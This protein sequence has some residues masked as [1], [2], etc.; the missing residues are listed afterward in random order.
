LNSTPLFYQNA[1]VVFGIILLVFLSCLYLLFCERGVVHITIYYHS[2][3][4]S[5]CIFKLSCAWRRTTQPAIIFF[6]FSI[7]S[8]YN[9]IGQKITS[10]EGNEDYTG[11]STAISK[12]G[13]VIAVGSIYH[14]TSR[15]NDA[16]ISTPQGGLVRIYEW[17]DTSEEWDQMGQNI[18]GDLYTSNI[19][20]QLGR[21][22]CLS[23]DGKVVAIYAGKLAYAVV[24]EWKEDDAGVLNWIKRATS[25]STGNF[26]DAYYGDA[27]KIA[28]SNDGSIFA[29]GDRIPKDRYG[30]KVFT[31]KWENDT[32][33]SL[34][35][36]WKGPSYFPT[37]P[38]GRGTRE[39]DPPGTTP[40]VNWGE[41]DFGSAVAFSDDG[42]T[43]VIGCQSGGYGHGA[44][45][46]YTFVD[47][48]WVIEY[49]WISDENRKPGGSFGASV[50]ISGDGKTI[51]VGSNQY[52]CV[53]LIKDA[54]GN[55]GE[56]M[57]SMPYN[58]TLQ[59]DRRL[60]S[61]V[62]HHANYFGH[63]ASEIALSTDGKV[64]CVSA[65]NTKKPG[66]VGGEGAI[67]IF[68][69]SDGLPGA[70]VRD[71]IYGDIT[72]DYFGMGLGMSADGSRVIGGGT[73]RWAS[74]STGTK[75]KGSA[76]VYEFS[77][78]PP[79]IPES[80]D[81]DAPQVWL[82]S[83]ITPADENK[84]IRE[85]IEANREV[86][87]NLGKSRKENGEI[88]KIADSDGVE[89]PIVI[90][91]GTDNKIALTKDS[92]KTVHK[93]KRADLAL[94]AIPAI[95]PSD[96]EEKPI[97]DDDTDIILIE[98]SGVMV[99]PIEISTDGVLLYWPGVE[100]DSARYIDNDRE[101][102]VTV[103]ADSKHTFEV[104][105]MFDNPETHAVYVVKV[106][107]DDYDGTTPVSGQYLPDGA[108]LLPGDVY[109]FTEN[110]MLYNV[111]GSNLSYSV[112][113]A[114]PKQLYIELQLKTQDGE[115]LAYSASENAAFAPGLASNCAFKRLVYLNKDIEYHFNVDTDTADN[116]LQEFNADVKSW[117]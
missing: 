64:L 48:A 27:P 50:C 97:I 26:E 69:L 109:K 61:P 12:D 28:L 21:R 78:D 100:G 40:T 65:Y 74:A 56:K 73:R 51:C 10:F 101:F 47:G 83:K 102:I 115:I 55:W 90:S 80:A 45:Y 57:F 111:V 41:N 107:N 6:V 36:I 96:P 16:W 20:D 87:R 9:K 110:S 60:F 95:N 59:N 33:T 11:V 70:I 92:I 2:L 32:W 89:R 23:G 84:S 68:E 1:F 103:G 24:Y 19:S 72:M 76:Q 98:A 3:F 79:P 104:L 38:R 34:G 39:G 18:E 52:M 35:V 81:L 22:I 113:T 85:N 8:S 77:L 30:E 31:Y 53:V 17:N 46:V 44:A 75:Y 62:Q 4:I 29:L 13:K 14:N 82:T 94:P 37:D 63:G 67:Y 15:T 54:D 42:L 49:Q 91:A 116:Q 25:E 105:N 5:F 114:T 88:P 117:M 99:T 108:C 58:P 66:G 43:M 112:D 86:I 7:M 106:A 93:F 71:A